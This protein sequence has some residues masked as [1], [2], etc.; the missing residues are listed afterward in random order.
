MKCV[1]VI[2]SYLNRIEAYDH[3]GPALNSIITVNPHALDTA[4]EMDRLDTVTVR[5]RPLHCIPVILKDNYDTADMPTTGGSLTLAKLVPAADGFVV[6]RLRQAGAI[7][8][9]KAN[10]MELAW[11]GTT[12]SSLGGQTRNPYDLTRTPGGS[13]GGTAAAIAASFGVIGTGSDTGQSIRSPSSANSL[14]GVRPT[15]GLVSRAGIIP[16]STTQDAAGPITRTVDDAARTLDV[17]ERSSGQSWIASDRMRRAIAGDL[18]PR[19]HTTLLAK[20]SALAIAMA[21]ATGAA[22]RLGDA[23]AATFAAA[24]AAGHGGDDD[25][26]LLASLREFEGRSR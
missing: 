15:R 3:R 12:V 25:A 11:S 14:V 6:K 21:G 13:S 17:I 24:V 16:L 7:V 20:D 2:Q 4:A 18:A 1:Q 5:Q 9:A 19:A 8:V 23:A 26:S 22:P 10:L